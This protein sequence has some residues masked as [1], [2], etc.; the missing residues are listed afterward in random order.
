MDLDQVFQSGDPNAVADRL[1][2]WQQEFNRQIDGFD[3]V[4]RATI[5]LRVTESAVNGG[6]S[7]TVDVTGQVVDI[8]TGDELETLSTAEIGPTVLACIRRAQQT[9]SDRF[10]ETA[11]ETVGDSPLGARLSE[12]FRQRFP[13]PREPKPRE[14]PRTEEESAASPIAWDEV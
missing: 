5:D 8:V 9:L 2:R 4:Q 6:L 3:R 1:E 11:T 10:A 14:R 7:V 12:Q 13:E